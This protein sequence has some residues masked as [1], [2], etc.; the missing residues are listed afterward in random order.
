VELKDRLPASFSSA[1]VL[2]GE[3]R[4]FFGPFGVIPES[5]ISRTWEQHEISHWFLDDQRETQGGEFGIDAVLEFTDGVIIASYIAYY[6]PSGDRT[7]EELMKMASA[8][9]FT[10]M[11]DQ[12][13]NVYDRAYRQW[14]DLMREERL[15]SE[16]GDESPKK[17]ELTTPFVNS[18]IVV[19]RK[20]GEEDDDYVKRVQMVQDLGRIIDNLSSRGEISPCSEILRG[21]IFDFIKNDWDKIASSY[22]EILRERETASLEEAHSDGLVEKITEK[23]VQGFVISTARELLGLPGYDSYSFEVLSQAF[24]IALENVAIPPMG[25][26]TAGD[27]MISGFKPS[28]SGTV[29]VGEESKDI[30]VA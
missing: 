26:E 9:G 24:A 4:D 12:D 22:E 30:Y 6:L 29:K 14:V 3:M 5:R 18:L 11:S 25:E 2:Q 28:E 1:G 7:P 20:D 13:R 10:E 27:F 15:K 16:L 8:P 19:P 17:D 21:S 23:L